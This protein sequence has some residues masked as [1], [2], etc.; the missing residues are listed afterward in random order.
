V[1]GG[2]LGEMERQPITGATKLNRKLSGQWWL[3]GKN[4]CMGDKIR[5]EMR[6]I[7]EQQ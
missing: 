4:W 6:N 3:S 5:T 2:G 1:D 7:N